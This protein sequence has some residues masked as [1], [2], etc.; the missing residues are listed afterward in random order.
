MRRLLSAPCKPLVGKINYYFMKPKVNQD[1]CIGSGSCTATC[2]EV[3][4]MGDDNKSHI[5][6]AIDYA[7]YKD[8]IDEAKKGC[9]VQAISWEE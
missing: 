3:F 8:S 2:P 7:K 5:V 1:I 4:Q 6:P 9:P